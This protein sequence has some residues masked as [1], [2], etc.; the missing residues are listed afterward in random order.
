MDKKIKIISIFLALVLFFNFSIACKSGEFGTDEIT[1]PT[2]EERVDSSAVNITYDGSRSL[3]FGEDWKFVL[4]NSG[5]ID[6]PAGEYENAQVPSFDDSA[7]RKLDLPHDWSIELAPVAGAGTGTDPGTGF[8]QGGLGWYRKTFILPASMEDKKISIE[9]DGIYMDSFVYLNGELLGNY[10]YGYTGFSFDLTEL[11]YTD[12]LTPNAI[13]IK[14]QNPLPS[15][16]WYSGSGIYRNVRLIVTNGIFV[17]RWGTFVTTPDLE[18]T[19]KD[20]YANVNIKTDISNESGKT[21]TVE[22]VSRIID[23]DGKVVAQSNSDATVDGK[24]YTYEDDI[25]VD[26]PV[27]WSFDNPYLYILESDLVVEG[28]VIDTYITTFGIRYFKIDPNEGFSLNSEYTKIQGVNLH[29]DLG[30]LGSAV[31]YDAILRQMKIMKDMGVNAI[32]TAHNPPAPEVLRAADRSG[33]LLVVEA[34]DCWQTGK[35]TYDYGRFFNENSDMDIKEMVDAAKNSPS[36]IMW[37]IGN[38]IRNP[39][40]ETAQI[41]IDAIKSIDTTR[42]VVWGSDGYRSIPDDNSPFHKILLLLDGVGLNYNTASSVDALHLKYPDKFIFESESSSSTSTRGIYQEADNLNTGENYTPGRM[43]PSSYD[44]NMASWTMSGEYGLKKDRDRKFFIGEF[45]WSGFD[46]IGEPTP[47]FNTFPVKSSF[48][49]AVDTAGFQKDLYHLF[50]SQWTSEPMVHL[51][52]MNWTDYEPG[53]EVQVWAYAN[54]DTVELFLNGKSMGVRTFDQKTTV[55]GRPYLETTEATFDDKTMD[56]GPYPGSYTSPKGSAGK[57]HLIWNVPFEEGTL[58]AIATQDGEEVARDEITTAGSPYT[59]R[60]TTD[61]KA[62][63]ANG[64]SLSFI[65][66]EVIDSNGVVVPGA[67]NLI[68]FTVTGGMIAGVDNGRQES[69]ES[70]KASYREAFNGKALVMIQS[71]D[72][73]GSI[74]V[75]AESSGLLPATTTIYSIA[76][77][78]EKEFISIEPVYIRTKKDEA[79]V[80]PE[81]VQAIY[82]DGSIQSLPV[83]WNELEED[84]NAICGIYTVEGQ[85]SGESTKAEAIIAVYDIGAIES[86][87]TVV[88]TGTAPVLPTTVR[89]VYNDGVDQFVPVIWGSIDPGDYESSG[90]FTVRGTVA[91]TTVKAEATIRVT[92][93]VVMDQNIASSESQLKPVA[94]ASYTG[95]IET[96][97]ASI[98]DG[99]RTSGGWSNYYNKQETALLPA[100]SEARPNDWVSITWPNLQ[101]IDNLTAYFLVSNM[102]QSIKVSYWNGSSFVQVSDVDITWATEQNPAT[103]ITFKLVETTQLRLDMESKSPGIADGFLRVLELEVISDVVTYNTTASLTDLKINGQTIEGFDSNKTEYSISVDAEMPEISAEVADNGR[104]AI[105]PPLILPGT[106]VIYAIS[107]DGLT[108]TTYYIDINLDN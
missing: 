31:N 25:R 14:V 13:A 39:D 70:F 59:L 3:D 2:S 51:L 11:V 10:H 21:E 47:Y 5:G 85:V 45:L 68:N 83:Q 29:H 50:K 95:T 57:L 86:Y 6:D 93:D 28:N 53:E 17:Q 82:T 40:I 12:G 94:D 104:M 30:A 63:T 4:V 97:P 22:L 33:I 75:K 49:G 87:S 80:L 61:D 48:F 41:L 36:V 74:T 107:E 32:R 58:M 38:E 37:S 96:L 76:E 88:T 34:F 84:L 64:K 98:L 106:V 65:T 27:L 103:T 1:E 26:D 100:F 8:L 54:V 99:N 55:D 102:P 105:V 67:D 78:G 81:M 56:D 90:Q 66:V 42:P 101:K 62:I 108:E 19:Y 16:R 35:T 44:N 71:T 24:D 15:S 89:L 52:P 7:W 18:N 73:P 43:G 77:T 69:I 91:E 9:F 23:A 60:L 20:D 46:Y 79:S 92:D 72:I